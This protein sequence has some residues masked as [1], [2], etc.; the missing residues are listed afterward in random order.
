MDYS[1]YKVIKEEIAAV[2]HGLKEING[3]GTTI[4]LSPKSDKLYTDI[5]RFAILLGFSNGPA[6]P[7]LSSLKLHSNPAYSNVNGE[8]VSGIKYTSGKIIITLSAT[9]RVSG[10]IFNDNITDTVTIS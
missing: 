8:M 2:P 10:L 6:G 3:Y 7:A 1:M 9:Y 5:S 4:T